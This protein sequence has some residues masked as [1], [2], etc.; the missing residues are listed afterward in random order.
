MSRSSASFEL[1]VKPSVVV[2]ITVFVVFVVF[3]IEIV[4]VVEIV[5]VILFVVFVVVGRDVEFDRRETGDLEVAAALRAAQLIALVDLE[6]VDFDLRVT[7]RA[8]GHSVSWR[9]TVAF[10]IIITML[11]ASAS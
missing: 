7:F 6:L 10:Q 11:M 4:V 8:S 1:L 9:L 3:V 2:R 5:V